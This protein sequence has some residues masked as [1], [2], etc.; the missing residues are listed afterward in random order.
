[1]QFSQAFFDGEEFPCVILDCYVF[2]F[3]KKKKEEKGRRRRSSSS[4]S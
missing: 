4:A 3:W 1:M 2:S